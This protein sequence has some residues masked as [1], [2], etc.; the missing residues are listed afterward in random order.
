MFKTLKIIFNPCLL[1][2]AILIYHLH[3]KSSLWNFPGGL[4]LQRL[5]YGGSTWSWFSD[6]LESSQT[7]GGKNL[8]VKG[9]RVKKDCSEIIC[10]YCRPTCCTGKLF[11]SF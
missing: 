10:M 6:Y 7:T 4:G 3:T 8:S 11:M 2:H 5:R 9:G 1:F